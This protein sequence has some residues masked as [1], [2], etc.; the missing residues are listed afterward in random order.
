MQTMRQK[1]AV[2]AWIV[3]LCAVAFAAFNTASAQAPATEG[4]R[5]GRFIDATEKSGIKFQHQAP[6]T[7]RKYLIETMGSGVALFDCDN[8]GRLDIFFPNGA[9]Y[10][11]PTPK[12]F[13]PQKAGP[14][15]W[16][17]MFRQKTDGTFE[18]ITEKAGLKGVGYSMG[19]A[20]ADYDNDGNEDLFIT[21]YGGNRLYHN[22]GNCTFTDVTEQTGVG[23]S[24][25]SSSATWADLDNDGLLDLVVARYVEWDWNDL[26]CGEH[27]EGYRGYCHPD[28]FQPISMLVYHNEG[29][30][31][32][33]EV[34]H[35]LGLDVPAKAL[36]VA[37]ADYDQDGRID[38]FVANDSMPEFLFH[39]KKDG[40]F[41]EVGLE[42]EVA[43]NSEGKTYAGMG[44]DFADYNNDGWPDLVITDLANQRYALYRNLGD[45]TFD[46]ASFTSGLGGMT[47]LHSGWSLRFLDYDND[48]WKDLL[49]AQ[50]HD[51]DTIEK[52]FPQ[53]HYREPMMLARNTGK[54][55]VDV[56]GVSSEI[57]H[58][59]WVGRGMAIGDINNDGRID[60]VVS[61]NGG[62]PHLLL[63]MTETSN[64]W[65][66][67]KLVGHKSNRD[68]IGAQVKLTTK[69]GSQWATVTTSSGYMSASDPRLH[70]GLGTAAA[71]DRIEIR[72][73]S[74][75]QQVLTDQVAD[76]QITIEE[77]A[78]S[79]STTPAAAADRPAP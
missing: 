64:H 19:V 68:A 71:I 70:F 2:G 62:A 46:Y 66:T 35:K 39:Q 17:R 33:T 27:R 1:H 56:S 48:G 13:I 55:F 69:L 37:I 50:G 78:Q 23:G 21:G 76:R 67:L 61:T 79:N 25:W 52:S 15:D 12:G 20:V 40:T 44:V 14:Q 45:S 10:T 74:G 60:A 54:R 42:S 57:F 8:D 49:I 65:I 29:H 72:W 30:G 75:I 73:P 31:R 16:N 5:P 51:L 53:L 43:V 58:D 9:P 22:S 26:W 7:S 6:H 63:N 11:D 77:S 24:G 36:G 38:L 18:D 32:F 3:L 41:E 47:M 34:A 4:Q 28:V 59:A